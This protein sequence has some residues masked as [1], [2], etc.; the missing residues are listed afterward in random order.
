MNK[1]SFPSR[2]QLAGGQSVCTCVDSSSACLF[3]F[4]SRR[5]HPRL[6]GDWSSD[7][8]SSDLNHP[9]V[10][11]PIDDAWSE[12]SRQCLASAQVEELRD[13]LRRW[14]RSEITPYPYNPAPLE[15]LTSIRSQLELRP[16]APMAVAFTNC[17]WDM[18]VVD[19]DVGFSSMFDWLFALV[20]YA[21]AHSGID[22]VVRAH[23]SE[24]NVSSD[25]QSRTPAGSEILKRYGPLP[26]NIK[27]V[28][29]QSP[30]SSY[31]LADMAHVVILYASRIGLEVALRGKRPWL[32]GNVT[33]RG[34]GFTR[35]LASKEEMVAL[36][37][38]GTFGDTL[39][40]DEIELAERFAYLWFFR[41]VTR[42]PL[43]RPRGRPFALKTFRELA[44]GGHPVI[45]NLCEALVTGAPFVDLHLASASV[46]E[47]VL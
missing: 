1:H 8:C 44:P 37:D 38:A 29:G 5:R 23:P 40:A 36:L 33:Y 13:F 24:T 21:V 39:S 18:A 14:A 7:V 47:G 22:L 25:L 35:D 17:A 11:I 9:A 42:L 15:D 3:F 10:E 41:Y 19:R 46:R 12:A 45:D 28:G 43:L 4:S 26:G 27:L 34:K 2:T 20:E 30:I 31:A 32:A 6:Q 16:G